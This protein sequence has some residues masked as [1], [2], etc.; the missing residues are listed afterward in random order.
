MVMKWEYFAGTTIFY[1]IRTKLKPHQVVSLAG[2]F[3][4]FRVSNGNGH[5]CVISGVDIIKGTITVMDPEVGFCGG[6]VT[7][8]GYQY[9]RTD[10][11]LTCLLIQATCRYWST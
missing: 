6:T 8:S 11:G 3:G 2:I 10:V 5:A 1:F 9:S 7:S 4:T